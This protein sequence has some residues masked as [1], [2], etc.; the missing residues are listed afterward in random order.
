[1]HQGAVGDDAEVAALFD[2]A[3][4]AKGNRK[5]GTGILRAV[6]RLTVEMFVLEEHHWVVAAD[7]S[8]QKTGDVQ[9]RG[10]HYHAQAGAMGENRFATLAVIDAATGEVAADGDAQ[11]YRRFEGA[12]R[13]PAHHAKLIANL[14]HGRPDVV[15][16]L[17]LSN[18][19]QAAGRHADGAADDA[20]FSERRIEN[21][22][23]AVLAL[24][25]C[26]CFEDAALAFHVLEVVLAAGIGHVFAENHDALVARHFVGE[27]CGNHL[28]HG[29]GRAMELRLRFECGRGG[30]HLRGIDVRLNRVHRRLFGGK[31][32]IR[33]IADFV[34]NFGF[35][36]FNLLLVE[37]A[38][39]NEDEGKLRKW[40]TP[41]FL[42]ALFR[43]FVELFVIGER[44]G[45]GARHM[46]VDE[47]RAA[48][49]AAILYRFFADGVAFERIRAVNF[50]NVQPRKSTY[51]FGNASAGG[52]YFHWN[53]N[54]I[55][56]IFDEIEERKF[57][58]AS[59]VQGFPEFALAGGAFTTRDVHDFIGLVAHVFPE[60]RLLCLRQ[61][62]GPPFVIER[63]LRGAHRL[64]ELRARAG[65]LADDVPLCM[66]PV[67][68]HLPAAGTEV[69]LCPNRGKKVLQGSYPK[70]QAKSAIAVIGIKPVNAGAE[71][72]A[73]DG[74]N[75]LM[76]GAGNLKIDFV[77][78]LELD[79]AIIQPPR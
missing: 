35:E 52:L 67:R 71:E 1:M 74:G 25:T 29:L 20:G 78:T 73:H 72:E 24:Q 28:D 3:G 18:G 42:F 15:K 75:R 40:I 64:Y 70:H 34:V 4:L 32:L 7:G 45:I 27:R 54:G 8:A 38:F 41:G 30:I 56:V 9:R 26:G 53:R 68:G 59:D 10:R 11:N 22:I 44:V 50:R 77:L 17:N 79:L 48:L 23:V 21:A 62:F 33:G 65:G 6:V 49:L 12:I 14:H 69:I 57:F 13:T 19:L 5:I 37:H 46:R 43:G 60:R 63:G 55:A 39:A 51:K 47:R 61:C 36:G 76:P 31:S 58:G 16:E 66:P 2:R